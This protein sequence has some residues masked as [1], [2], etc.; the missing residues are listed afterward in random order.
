MSTLLAALVIVAPGTLVDRVVAVVDRDVV[1]HSELLRE[2]RVALVMREN[3]APA[4]LETFDPFSKRSQI[5][6]PRS[7]MVCQKAG[8]NVKHLYYQSLDKV[9]GKAEESTEC[10]GDSERAPA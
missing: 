1:T 6:T 3:P 2:A 9:R 8:V 7:L 4:N 10:S 5:A